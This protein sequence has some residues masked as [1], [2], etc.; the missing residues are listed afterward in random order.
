M[1]LV[2]NPGSNEHARARLTE[3]VTARIPPCADVPRVALQTYKRRQAARRSLWRERALPRQTR[4]CRK[5]ADGER[6]HRLPCEAEF[7]DPA[8]ESIAREQNLIIWSSSAA[9]A[10]LRHHQADGSRARLFGAARRD[11][12]QQGARVEGMDCSSLRRLFELGSF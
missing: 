7:I 4:L 1:R 12:L 5:L 11:K 3:R 10:A 6:M 8:P 9:A 2:T